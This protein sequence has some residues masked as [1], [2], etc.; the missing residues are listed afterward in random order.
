ML[1]ILEIPT[2]LLH[3][4]FIEVSE[5]RH[6]S[7]PRDV[8]LKDLRLLCHAFNDAIIPILFSR[9]TI[10]MEGFLGPTTAQ[11]DQLARSH[12][13]RYLHHVVRTLE[14]RTLDAGH[15]HHTHCTR[16]ARQADARLKVVDAGLTAAIAALT[17]LQ[18]VRWIIGRTDPVARVTAIVEGL[19]ALPADLGFGVR[20]EYFADS[21]VPQLLQLSTHLTSLSITMCAP[22]NPL[23]QRLD[24]LQ[25]LAALV[26]CS[27]RLDRLEF[28]G[29]ATT[30]ADPEDTSLIDF[31]LDV[32]LSAL[33]PHHTCPSH[34]VLDRLRVRSMDTVHYMG[35]LQSLTLFILRSRMNLHENDMWLSQMWGTLAAA[36]VFPPS[37]TTDDL[38]S[39][40]IDYLTRHPGLDALILPTM[41]DPHW[42]LALKNEHHA[43]VTAFFAKALPR[44]TRTL[45][46]L[47]IEF[48]DPSDPVPRNRAITQCMLLETFTTCLLWTDQL[49]FVVT[50][51]KLLVVVRAIPRMQRLTLTVFQVRMFQI[52]ADLTPEVERLVW[53]TV[54]AHMLDDEVCVPAEVVVRGRRFCVGSVDGVR[55][56]VDAG[57]VGEQVVG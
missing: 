5:Q 6:R 12:E 15:T 29:P 31:D 35:A 40:L 24:D 28:H 23:V 14:I 41:R 55:R 43:L 30:Q 39:A 13:R 45:R 1:H 2:E 8:G 54:A 19:C 17:S 38:N 18:D 44:H 49:R 46:H 9:I 57:L 3:L 20:V 25:L 36:H 56:Y 26:A 48:L 7:K 51:D 47:C 4:I 27:P 37:I 50:F 53:N 21:M 11:I 33:P 16:R 22:D 32:I 34:L 10:T 52:D 42:R